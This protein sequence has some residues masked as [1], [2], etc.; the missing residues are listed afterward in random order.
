[1]A[2]R[3][4]DA[5]LRGAQAQLR[6]NRRPPSLALKLPIVVRPRSLSRSKIPKSEKAALGKALFFDPRLSG[7]QNMNCASCHNPSFGWEVPQRGA[8]GQGSTL[9]R[10]TPTILNQAWNG[11]YYNWDGRANSLEAQATGTIQA[12]AEMKIPAAELVQHLQDITEYNNWFGIVFP[13]E[14]VTAA[15][16]AKA[17]AT[18]ERTVVSGYAPFDAWIEGDEQAISDFAKR[19]FLLFAGKANCSA[20]HTG[21]TFPT[22][23]STTSAWK[24][25]ISVA[26]RS[27]RIIRRPSMRSRPRA[28][29]TLRSGPNTCTTVRCPICNQSLRIT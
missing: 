11:P 25:P 1:M 14:G 20:C 28:C 18:Y 15:T 16:I 8:I 13:G 6:P 23:S 19:G 3:H 27:S 24:R 22:I 2:H 9:S 10:N 21:G 12:K 5:P 7:N 26:R 4:G 17:L 29:A